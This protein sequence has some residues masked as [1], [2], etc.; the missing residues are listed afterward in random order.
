[1]KEL[2]LANSNLVA[3]VDDEDYDRLLPFKWNLNKSLRGIRVV[4]SMKVRHYW[5]SPSL[6]SQVM[7]QLLGYFDHIDRNPLNNQKYNLRSATHQQNCF[8]TSKKKNCASQYK[9]VCWHKP[10]QKWRAKVHKAGK[11]YDLGY[12]VYE[13]DAAL[14]Y[15]AKALELFGEF[16]TL[17]NVYGL[18]VCS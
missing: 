15:N 6:A 5:R 17:N 7:N 11:C 13:I 4:R 10:T 3:L 9:G 2:K 16:A 14:A 8:N 18:P 1:M 12:H